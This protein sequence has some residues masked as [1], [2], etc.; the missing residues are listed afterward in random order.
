M[1][2]CCIIAGTL[3]T[4]E[5]CHILYIL[6]PCSK[7][8]LSQVISVLNQNILHYYVDV[9]NKSGILSNVSM[10]QLS[11]NERYI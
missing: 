11:D 4:R 6:V 2:I 7:V 10:P 3:V 8:I 1:Y 5:V 9:R